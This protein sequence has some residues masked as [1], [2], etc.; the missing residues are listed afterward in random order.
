MNS[1][2]FSAGGELLAY[3]ERVEELDLLR[4]QKRRLQQHSLAGFIYLVVSEK[5]EPDSSQ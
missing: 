5:T 3:E 2:G 1:T 4:L